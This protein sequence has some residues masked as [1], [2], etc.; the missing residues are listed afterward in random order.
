MALHSSLDQPWAQKRLAVHHLSLRLKSPPAWLRS[1]QHLLC[2][3]P[4]GGLLFSTAELIMP[5]LCSIC[6]LLLWLCDPLPPLSLAR[7]ASVCIFKFN[8]VSK[9]GEKKSGQVIISPGWDRTAADH[10]LPR[11]ELVWIASLFLLLELAVI[12][13]FL[14]LIIL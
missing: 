2:C 10:S 7:H 5:S 4:L 12:I 13:I 3:S 1:L 6:R 9:P 14:C 8:F 11:S